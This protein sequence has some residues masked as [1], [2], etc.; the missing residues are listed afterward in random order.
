MS[1]DSQCQLKIRYNKQLRVSTTAPFLS[2][3]Q[4]NLNH[5]FTSKNYLTN[6]TQTLKRFCVQNNY[7]MAG[8]WKKHFKDNQEDSV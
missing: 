4:I 5:E 6:N 8:S 3:M 2:F 1:D 7:Y